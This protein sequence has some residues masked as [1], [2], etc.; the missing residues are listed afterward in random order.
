MASGRWLFCRGR[1]LLRQLDFACFHQDP[2]C[3]DPSRHA[4]LSPVTRYWLTRCA[5]GAGARPGPQSCSSPLGYPVNWL[6]FQK[7][8]RTLF[9]DPKASC[10][11]LPVC[12]VACLRRLDGGRRHYPF[13]TP[14]QNFDSPELD[15]AA[16]S[17][18]R[19]RNGVLNMKRVLIIAVVVIV[20]VAALSTAIVLRF[21]WDQSLTRL[22]REGTIRIGYAVEAP[23][24]FL[25][26]GGEVTGESPE[27]AKVI[28]GRLG[29]RHI[30]WRQS[31]FGSLI[32]GLEAGRFDV[33]AAGI[34]ITPERA[35]RISFSEPTF[36][37]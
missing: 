20:I 34:F 28:V 3:S 5:V 10:G 31:E 23:Y 26:P 7:N 15:L 6:L 33:I 8:W 19:A 27:V 21:P 16:L 11:R 25:K 14:P 30:E 9:K 37:V 18:G 13:K 4:Q 17:R 2:R 12:F 22:Q 36:H 35:R 32:S 29:I 24:A 1:P